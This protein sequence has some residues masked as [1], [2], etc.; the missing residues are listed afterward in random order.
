MVDPHPARTSCH[1]PVRER[2]ELSREQLAPLTISRRE[3]NP[4]LEVYD[5]HGRSHSDG[6]TEHGSDVV[7][8][9]ASEVL[10]PIVADR[11]WR[12]YRPAVADGLRDDAPGDGRTDRIHILIRTAVPFPEPWL[13]LIVVVEF[14]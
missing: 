9:H 11:R 3:W 12:F 13:T 4:A 6:C 7:S 2:C 8:S 10:E 5:S 14:Q 1:Q